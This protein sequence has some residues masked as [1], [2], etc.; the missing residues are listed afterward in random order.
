MIFNFRAI[1]ASLEEIKVEILVNQVGGAIRWR[2]PT[3]IVMVGGIVKESQ[4]QLI[5]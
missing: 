5:K 2:V 4:F 3:T 1:P